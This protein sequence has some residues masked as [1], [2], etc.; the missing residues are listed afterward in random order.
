VELA[1]AGIAGDHLSHEIVEHAH[2]FLLE[3]FAPGDNG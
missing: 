2:S 1:L 3:G